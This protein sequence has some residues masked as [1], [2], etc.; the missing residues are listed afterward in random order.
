[1]KGPATTPT[2][3]PTMGSRGHFIAIQAKERDG[4]GG[5]VEIGRAAQ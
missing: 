1:M 4:E 5:K 2:T 3:V